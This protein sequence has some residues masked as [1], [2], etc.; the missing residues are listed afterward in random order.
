MLR[1]TPFPTCLNLHLGTDGLTIQGFMT[2]KMYN[3]VYL[4]T[5]PLGRCVI[6][7]VSKKPMTSN[8]SSEFKQK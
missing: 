7:I 5:N 8:L 4:V 2:L 6:T 3:G 1:F